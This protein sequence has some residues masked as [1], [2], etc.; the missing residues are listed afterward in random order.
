[1]SNIVFQEI[2]GSFNNHDSKE[3][4]NITYILGLTQQE[5]HPS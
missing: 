1:M 3:R 5:P 4:Q 2:L